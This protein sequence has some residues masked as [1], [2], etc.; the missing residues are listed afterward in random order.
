MTR[1]HLRALPDLPLS[2]VTAHPDQVPPE[3]T[4]AAPH[5][6]DHVRRELAGTVDASA[7]QPAVWG[8]SEPRHRLQDLID[9]VGDLTTLEHL[10]T[11]PLPDEPFAWTEVPGQFVPLFEDLVPLL[12]SCADQWLTV[13]H[14]TAM[15]RFA[16]TVALRDPRP[17]RRGPLLRRAAAIAW[18]VLRA[19]DDLGPG[20][21][22]LMTAKDLSA[23][24]G[25][26]SE[27]SGPARSMLR[28]GG[29]SQHET[30]ARRDRVQLGDAG[31][32]TARR[33]AQI[34]MAR[35]RRSASRRTGPDTPFGF[36]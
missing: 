10:D 7:W 23:R 9:L 2:P 26:R 28:A 8:D 19:N 12:D 14:R 27:V 29:G 13:E 36:S 20:R 21:Q 35:D 34:V 11:G 15:R 24:F 31:L 17:L 32:L 30:Y 18:V 22:R 3:R 16:A 6:I 1:R 5:T 4:R 33:R 25:L